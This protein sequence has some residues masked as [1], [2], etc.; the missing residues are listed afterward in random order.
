MSPQDLTA[1]RGMDLHD[2]MNSLQQAADLDLLRL[3]HAIDHLLHSPSRILAVRQRLHLGQEV[4]FWNLRTNRMQ[5][6]RVT[7]FK[8]DQLM[9][10]T[11]NPAQYWWV[12][13]AAIQLDPN[14]APLPQPPRPLGR[15]E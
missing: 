4:R 14:Q 15:S 10:L 6:G 11:E 7:Q 8:P 3:S 13:Y 1:R 12:S 9:L 5:Q 2:V